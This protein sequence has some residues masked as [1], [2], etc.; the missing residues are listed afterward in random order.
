MRRV[1]SAMALAGILGGCASNPVASSLPSP[2]APSAPANV[3]SNI[4]MR[5]HFLYGHFSWVT[6][7][8]QSGGRAIAQC[9]AGTQ[10]I[11]GGSNS[12]DGA[13]VGTGYAD[14]NTNSWIVKDTSSQPEAFASCADSVVSGD[15][16]WVPQQAG[17]DGIAEAR[18]PAGF[19][20][21]TGFALGAKFQWI[22]ATNQ[23]YWATGNSTTT[24]YASC[25]SLSSA[26][27]NKIAFVTKS[28]PSQDPQQWTTGCPSNYKPIGGSFGTQQYPGGADRQFPTTDPG[29]GFKAYSGQE[30]MTVYAVCA[31]AS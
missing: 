18:C 6:Q 25:T 19:S 4:K 31:E 1:I 26:N 27:G 13:A 12:S 9:P 3:S 24:A 22:D 5:P 14:L 20:V 10:L 30:E 28:A 8:G 29:I 15:F 7:W 17:S 2:S 11:A 16:L 23:S 21:V